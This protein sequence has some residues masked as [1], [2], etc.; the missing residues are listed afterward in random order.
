M[1]KIPSANIRSSKTAM[2]AAGGFWPPA[3]D[4]GFKTHPSPLP[5]GDPGGTHSQRMSLF[6]R[7]ITQMLLDQRVRALAGLKKL[8]DTQVLLPQDKTQLLRDDIPSLDATSTT[9]ARDHGSPTPLPNPQF[10]I[11]LPL[12]VNFHDRVVTGSHCA[13][14]KGA[15]P[16]GT[17]SPRSPSAV[18]LGETII[19]SEPQAVVDPVR[20][21]AGALQFIYSSPKAVVEISAAAGDQTPP[22]SHRTVLLAPFSSHRSPR[23]VLLAASFAQPASLSQLRSAIFAQ[24]S[25]LCDRMTGES[26]TASALEKAAST[27]SDTVTDDQIYMQDQ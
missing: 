24:P 18:P 10:S 11:V 5:P 7:C 2:M 19:F 27:L 20:Q 9:L 12:A 15:A 1:K 23:T 26:V 16:M 4:G 17:P 25:S 8:A 13:P 14:T 6:R 3:G 22:C 21:P